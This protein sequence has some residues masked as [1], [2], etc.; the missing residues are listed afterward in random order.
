M[1]DRVAGWWRASLSELDRT[2]LWRY[3]SHLAVALLMVL[4]ASL[5]RAD[6]FRERAAPNPSSAQREASLPDF[7]GRPSS[8]MAG[9]LARAPVPRTTILK[10]EEARREVI[11]YTVEP[12][13]TL[14]DLAEKFGVSGDTIVWANTRLEEHPDLIAVGQA[15]I[16]P[17]VSGVLHTVAKGDTLE[18]IAKKYKVDVSAIV[19]SEF[20][21]LS[22]PY[23][24]VV[25]QR[26]MVPEGKKPEVPRV[27]TAQPQPQVAAPRGALVGTGRFIWPTSG[28]ITQGYWAYHR[29]IDIG[30]PIGTLIYASDAGYVEVA[31]WSRVGYGYHVIIDHGNGFKTL[32]AH[33]SWF[34]VVPGQS[35]KRGE[36]IGR[37]GSTGWSTGP[38]VHFE[39]IRNGIKLNPFGYLP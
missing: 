38:H 27:V 23:Q 35:V 11:T 9:F 15:L 29:A 19:S 24:L 5:A 37:V 8:V 17:P 32:Y 2:L 3:L 12:G 20:N 18:G 30:S 14:Y 34:D 7:S 39:I 10:R 26:I 36:L 22:E 1:Q 31:G 13:D 33:M 25:G 21:N 4:T 28:Q 16:I 6:L